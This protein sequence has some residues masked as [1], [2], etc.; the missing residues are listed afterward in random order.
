MKVTYHVYHD[1]KMRQA[2]ASDE[3]ILTRKR[4]DPEVSYYQTTAYDAKRQKMYFYTEPALSFGV[5][6][7]K[8]NRLVRHMPMGSIPHISCMGDDGM[9]YLCGGSDKAPMLARYD[10]RT[11]A[12]QPLGPIQAEDGTVCYRTHDLAVRGNTA[13]IA[14]TDNPDR[15]GYLWECRF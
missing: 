7:L 10:R 6:D 11:N 5:Y 14:E 13:Y 3:E 1:I 4:D 12:F 8:A 15:S 9:I 2:G